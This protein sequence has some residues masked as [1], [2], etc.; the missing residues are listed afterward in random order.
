M[1]VFLYS[2]ILRYYIN[3]QESSSP[4]K[5]NS[6]KNTIVSLYTKISL[7]IFN[8]SWPCETKLWNFAGFQGFILQKPLAL[9]PCRPHTTPRGL[10]L[11]AASPVSWNVSAFLQTEDWGVF[12]EIDM[13]HVTWVTCSTYST[14]STQKKIEK[15]HVQEP[16]AQIIANFSPSC[17][18]LPVPNLQ[19]Q[20]HL[21]GLGLKVEFW[22]EPFKELG[23]IGLNYVIYTMLKYI[24]I[25]TFKIIYISIQNKSIWKETIHPRLPHWMFIVLLPAAPFNITWMS[26]AGTIFFT[27][28][29]VRTQTGPELNPCNYIYI[30]I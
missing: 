25:I 18:E 15:A 3:R 20:G 24:F 23:K 16:T 14:D 4:Q 10:P 30:Y 5:N 1:Y 6:K 27:G 22:T 9:G 8:L 11:W 17:P 26:G 13:L 19:V 29:H 28:P 2:D 7:F 12:N 21:I